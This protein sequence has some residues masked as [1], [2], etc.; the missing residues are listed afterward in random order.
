MSPRS[1]ASLPLSPHKVATP[2]STRPPNFLLTD[3]KAES[4]IE[5]LPD[6][7]YPPSGAGGERLGRRGAG[8]GAGV[9]VTVTDE[10]MAASLREQESI[11]AYCLEQVIRVVEPS[12]EDLAKL[13]MRCALG[14]A[15]NYERTLL[16]YRRVQSGLEAKVASQARLVGRLYATVGALQTR[17]GAG[18]TA[19]GG[20]DGG[21]NFAT[22]KVIGEARAFEEGGR[23]LEREL[24]ELKHS[25]EAMLAQDPSGVS[26][27]LD[28]IYAELQDNSSQ[29]A[30]RFTQLLSG[31]LNPNSLPAEGESEKFILDKLKG[32]ALATTT[33]MAR[34]LM[35]AHPVRH[36]EVQTF[37]EMSEEY[38]MEMKIERQ[39]ELITEQNAKID[40]L[41][42]RVKTKNEKLAALMKEKQ[43]IAHGQRE[44]GSTM[45]DA[46]IE[47]KALAQKVDLLTAEL[48]A[49]EKRFRSERK[50][51]VEAADTA[52]K[53]EAQAKFAEHKVE[54]LRLAQLGLVARPGPGD[55][56]RDDPAGGSHAAEKPR[57]EQ[58][59]QQ[60]LEASH[61]DNIPF[62]LDD[63]F[64]R[65]TNIDD[66]L[67]S[68]NEAATEK[69]SVS[70]RL[71]RIE[72]KANQVFQEKKE[73]RER[74]MQ[75]MKQKRLQEEFKR[76][77]D[78]AQKAAAAKRTSAT[79]DPALAEQLAAMQKLKFDM[80][81]S[82]SPPP[83]SGGGTSRG[84]ERDQPQ[85]ESSLL[86]KK[87]ELQ[88]VTPSGGMDEEER[89]QLVES[90]ETPVPPRVELPSP[91]SGKS[92]STPRKSAQRVSFEAKESKKPLTAKKGGIGI[93]A[94][95]APPA[96]SGPKELEMISRKF[97]N[98]NKM[99]SFARGR[100]QYSATN[101]E[102]EEDELMIEETE[103]GDDASTHK[104]PLRNRASGTRNTSQENLASED[105]SMDSQGK[106]IKRKKR[107]V[108]SKTSMT[109]KHEI[110]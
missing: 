43:Q 95:A 87:S 94:K 26:E 36:R 31:G 63:A 33:R 78:E 46:R 29:T 86:S 62:E 27:D 70:S 108:L 79:L 41:E 6:E 22:K 80:S 85:V 17:G 53:A 19:G 44:A 8:V 110:D 18:G 107:S 100:K 20:G 92:P 64:K 61:F 39:Q 14:T 2:P 48:E 30:T 104:G 28:D 42:L 66:L 84:Q 11:Y 4:A 15:Q 51:A 106:F 98:F 103:E 9:T 50:R 49:S 47:I 38:V 67:Q 76:R 99:S 77:E 96:G 69:S 101:A 68:E 97:K 45:E 88:S 5:S 57:D 35:Q 37:K 105:G 74:L 7:L 65:N 59:K 40:D 10:E 56:L 90:L 89:D 75:E 82:R 109:P 13:L 52:K 23:R 54:Q 72:A 81:A 3:A 91:A 93:S 34:L 32:S 60:Q 71:S 12:S 21:Q 24:E 102:D 1:P 73:Q 25:L 83:A 55:R 16:F 58:Q